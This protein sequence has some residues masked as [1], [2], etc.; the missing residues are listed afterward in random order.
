MADEQHPIQCLYTLL[1]HF[2][3]YPKGVVPMPRYI[4]GPSFFPG[5]AGLTNAPVEGPLP[6]WPLGGVMIVAHNFDCEA[7]YTRA[8][9][10]P[11]SALARDT[12]VT[13]R[14]LDRLLT[15]AGIPLEQCFYTNAYVG[16]KEGDNSVGVFPGS[17]NADFVRQYHAFL[18]AQVQL[19]QPRLILSLGGD[20]LRF[21]A[22]WESVPDLFRAWAGARTTRDVDARG[23]ALVPDVHFPHVS[24]STTV[25]ALTHPAIW[26]SNVRWRR[27][28]AGGNTYEGAG[29]EKALLRDGIAR[30]AF[31]S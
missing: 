27:Y 14:T 13:R 10:M 16:L 17:R 1:E 29:A 24:H 6:P 15:E 2:R 8:M 22:M 12:S 11:P 7:G 28:S 4:G 26:A 25:V 9:R 30:C 21:L 19:Q 18:L 31:S 5:G 3:P 23:A 20:V